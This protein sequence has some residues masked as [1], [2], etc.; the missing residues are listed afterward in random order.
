MWIDVRIP[1]D[2]NG[3]LAQAYNR[4][5]AD[6]CS[7]WVLFLDH[8][9][10]MLNP[11][12]FEMCSNAITLLESADPKAACITCMAVG[13]RHRRTMQEKGEPESDIEKLIQVAKEEYIKHGLKLDRIHEHAAG[14]FMLL[15]REAALKIRFKQVGR[16]I[17]NIDVDFG[18]RLLATGYHIYQ[19]PGL[20]VY[21]RRGMKHLKKEFTR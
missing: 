3:H 11:R 20:Y 5:L 9:V 21:H 13:E 12:W 8:D 6:G 2:E 7:P 1:Y 18:T 15:N 10:F 17:N 16:S 4:D 14:Y 19:M